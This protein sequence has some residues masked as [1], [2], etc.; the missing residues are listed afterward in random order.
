MGNEFGTGFEV[1]GRR[2]WGARPARSRTRRAGTDV[3][4]VF[5]HWPGA[6]GNLRQTLKELEA[7]ADDCLLPV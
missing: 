1:V 6:T 2:E 7:E 5:V 3:N 4:T